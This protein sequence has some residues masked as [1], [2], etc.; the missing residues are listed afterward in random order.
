MNRLKI[1]QEEL[2]RKEEEFWD[3]K[4]KKIPHE[5]KGGYLTVHPSKHIENL[6]SGFISENVQKVLEIGCN[7]GYLSGYFTQK[8]FEYTGVDISGESIRIAQETFSGNDNCRFTL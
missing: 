4:A 1:T 8:G 3:D 2:N 5:Y 7:T 6:V